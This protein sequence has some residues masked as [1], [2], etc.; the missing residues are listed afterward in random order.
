MNFSNFNLY[1]QF[2]PT[3]LLYIVMYNLILYNKYKS[4]KQCHYNLEIINND[5]LRDDTIT[6]VVRIIIILTDFGLCVSGTK[7]RPK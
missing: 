4:S 3:S 1:Y 2:Q 5:L 6:M 7:F